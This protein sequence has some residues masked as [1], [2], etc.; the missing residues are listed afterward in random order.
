MNRRKSR[1]RRRAAP[2]T[3][4]FRYDLREMTA[5]IA[6]LN[7][8][9]V[10]LAADS[11]VTLW[12]GTS[13][14]PKIYNTV[15]KLFTLS[16]HEPVGVMIYGSATL[17]GLPVETS[18]K[19]FR[20]ELGR[21]A[22][23]SLQEY[24]DY[25]L[26]FLGS[27]TRLF[28]QDRQDRF[29][30]RGSFRFLSRVKQDLDHRVKARIKVEGEI[31]EGV[32]KD[33]LTALL[34]QH[35]HAVE[36]EELLGSADPTDVRS[37]SAAHSEVIDSVTTEVFEQAPFSDG[38][39]V[40]L[41]ELV[42]RTLLN[43]RSVVSDCGMVFAGLGTNDV[44]PMLV[45]H[46]VRGVVAGKPHYHFRKIIDGHESSGIYPFAQ[47]EMVSTFMEGISPAIKTTIYEY[48]H[49]ISEDLPNEIADDADGEMPS[50]QRDDLRNALKGILRS[51]AEQ[52][53]KELEA[54]IQSEQVT[55]V[56]DIVLS[57]PKNELA[58]MAETLVNLTS[59]RQRVSPD[60]ETVGGPVDVAI[61]SRGDGFIWIKRKHYFQAELNQQFFNNYFD[62]RK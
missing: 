31:S 20:D 8:E 38:Q 39:R 2:I 53:Q 18:V 36:G 30:R 4:S 24:A 9:A 14:A 60:A 12:D 51:A 50:D 55:P 57:L 49:R 54:C 40:L 45:Q 59:F 25:F 56:L 7:T 19:V 11:A 48:M 3:V 28:P 43:I 32:L 29:V 10:A 33:E 17:G 6:I 44:C 16:K 34:E 1:L 42:S 26:E 62:S 22:F 41:R 5:E 27:S 35:R 58:E 37:V 13:R 46:D 47:T 23:G 52:L 15:N 21:R 61:I